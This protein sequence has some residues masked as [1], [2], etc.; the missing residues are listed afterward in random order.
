MD[1]DRRAQLNWDLENYHDLSRRA[2]QKWITECF[3]EYQVPRSE[4]RQLRAE[5]TESWQA[6]REEL[7][8][9]EEQHWPTTR[10]G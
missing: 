3:N 2:F 4:R 8:A 6:N 1:D 10:W 9:W 5:A 7:R